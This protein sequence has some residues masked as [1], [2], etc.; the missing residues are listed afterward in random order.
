[1]KKD[2][3]WILDLHIYQIQMGTQTR[4]TITEYL[5]HRGSETLLGQYHL[6]QLA[7]PV[8]MEMRG[9]LVPLMLHPLRMMCTDQEIVSENELTGKLNI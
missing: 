9:A 1:M 8:H 4:N 6:Y 3:E 7:Q 2:K 5:V